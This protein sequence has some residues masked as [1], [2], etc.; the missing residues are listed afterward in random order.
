M[1]FAEF[2]SFWLMLEICS[3]A[4]SRSTRIEL[5]RKFCARMLLGSKVARN[6]SARNVILIES[7]RIEMLEHLKFL[8]VHIPIATT[9]F[10]WKLLNFQQTW[11]L[12]KDFQYFILSENV[13]SVNFSNLILENSNQV[14]QRTLCRTIFMKHI[15]KIFQNAK[16]IY[17]P[18]WNCIFLWQ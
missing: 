3:I 14:S 11:K 4:R 18:T 15:A 12:G 2:K 1:K 9:M 16:K 13:L 17:F 6:F 7:D 8:L 5:V 10:I